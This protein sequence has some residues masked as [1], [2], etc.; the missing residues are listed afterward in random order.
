MEFTLTEEG[1]A[2]QQLARDF[3]ERE[4][5]P[6]A[7]E[8]D[9]RPDPRECVPWE[10]I[11]KG[12]RLGLRTLGTPARW[13]GGGA[14]LLTQA[15]V[16]EEMARVDIGASKTFSHNWKVSS[17][18]AALASEEQCQRFL[19]PFVE[20]HRFLLSNAITEPDAGSDNFLPH[21]APEAGARCFAERRGDGYII[22]GRKT[23][24]ALGGVSRLVVL[25]ARTDR[26]VGVTKGLSTFLVPRGTPGFSVGHI[27]DKMGMRL[28]NNAEL[29]FEACRVP[30]ENL[31]G[32]EGEAWEQRQRVAG[33]GNIEVTAHAV[34]CA[35]GAYEHALEHARNRVQ[36]LRPITE[37][38]AIAMKLSEMA[39]EVE[40]GRTLLWRAA[41]S[42]DHLRPPDRKL[43]ILAKVFATEMA[44]RVARM[45]CEVW[46][47]MGVMR[48]AP[49][50]KL[51]RDAAVLLHMDGTNQINRIKAARRL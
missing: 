12:S 46:G 37:H 4:V 17:R 43:T 25:W 38:Q 32:A 7:A 11:E 50:E 30:A 20:D 9:R 22:N 3:F 8:Y 13:G 36:G 18:I 39:M 1:R 35:R 49:A 40:A 2:L 48:D 31:V 45:A 29:I 34:G 28:Y 23:F 41:W 27:H 42:A 21:D 14:D 6:M 10:L 26:S 19:P 5:R 33:G 47:G 16:I 44:V 51:L 24:I 15:M